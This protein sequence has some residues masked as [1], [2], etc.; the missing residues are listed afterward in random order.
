MQ[1]KRRGREKTRNEVLYR[2]SL[3]LRPRATLSPVSPRSLHI[4]AFFS[5]A[6]IFS[7]TN[8]KACQLRFSQSSRPALYE[9]LFRG[10]RAE[11]RARDNDATLTPFARTHA[12]THQCK[13]PDARVFMHTRMYACK[14]TQLR[15]HARIYVRPTTHRVSCESVKYT[16][17]VRDTQGWTLRS[18]RPC[19]SV[20]AY[21]RGVFQGSNIVISLGTPLTDS[22]APAQLSSLPLPISRVHVDAH[23][24][25]TNLS[26]FLSF[27]FSLHLLLSFIYIRVTS[28]R[29][30]RRHR[31]RHRRSRRS[32]SPPVDYGQ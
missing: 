2:T 24:M 11:M 20:L 29:H 17:A 25:P 13:R 8:R 18:G 9:E 16:S 12:C 19:T 21:T 15:L 27:S 3:S 7:S 1:Q 26:L 31:C 28:R 5:P 22:F 4:D 32:S 23:T 14:N 6:D 30:R 10:E